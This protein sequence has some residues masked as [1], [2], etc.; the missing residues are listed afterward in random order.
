[1]V[2]FNLILPELNQFISELGGADK[3]GLIISLFAITAMLSRPISGKLSDTIGRKKVM[4][5][6]ILVGFVVTMSYP[7]LAT[8]TVFLVLRFI[9]GLSAGFLPTGA[10]ALVTDILLPNQ[11]GSGMGLWGVFISLGIGVGQYLGSPIKNEFGM[12]MLFLVSA[13]F[14]LI[15]GGCILQLKETLPNPVK[16]KWSLLKLKF[17][18]VF[19]PHVR[20]AA[21]V[22]FLSASASGTIF[23]LSQDICGF[24][25]IPNKG[26]FFGIYVLATIFVRFF[27]GRL[28]DRIGR[29]QTLLI[30]M[31]IVFIS[32]LMVALAQ[33]IFVFG[34]SAVLF[35]IATGISSP[36][37]FSWTADLSPE[38]RR[39]VGA[40]TLFIAL[41][42]GIIVGSASTTL[43][44]DNTF[45]TI[46]N[47][48][49]PSLI[50]VIC[51]LFYLMYYI[52]RLNQSTS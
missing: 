24:L 13:L 37:L 2:S 29:P 1:M 20:P 7:L 28:S 50:L 27:S 42:F 46:F 39:G 3:K 49:L 25:H 15:A 12:T 8:V 40:G 51:S 18:D 38:E 10:T 43:T 36:T 5:M 33:S 9:H 22:M 16:F 17:D 19:E 4:L 34:L 6:G 41:E 45:D 30:G 44:Y 14:Y 48:F 47:A 21:M 32:V 31:S 35:G 11:R 26:W 52:M 23:V